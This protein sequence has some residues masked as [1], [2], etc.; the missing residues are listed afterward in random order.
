MHG[1]YGPA[2]G[3]GYGVARSTLR[4]AWA[5]LALFAGVWAA[6]LAALPGLGLRNPFWHYSARENGVDAGYHAV[7]AIG[8]AAA[9]GL[10]TRLTRSRRRKA[11]HRTESS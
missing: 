11:P 9:H 4:P 10:G 6:R 5:T 3:L 2:G 1:L 7:Y 8:V